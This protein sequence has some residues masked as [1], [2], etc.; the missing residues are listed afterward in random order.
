MMESGKKVYEIT[1]ELHTG[2]RF[3]VLAKADRMLKHR[4][5][6]KVWKLL[7][8]FGCQVAVVAPDLK[9]F[10]GSLIHQDLDSL[11]DK[12]D[13]IVPC[14]RP[15]YLEGLADKA[16]E[17]GAKYIWFQENNLTSVLEEQCREKNICVVRGCALKHKQYKKPLA[18]FNKCYWHGLTEKKVPGR[19]N[20]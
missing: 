4:H 3:V 6:W 18:F 16:E 17:A 10:E 20:K 15:E 11:K 12:V 14:L 5:A 8:N 7:K 1:D 2:M 19:Y 9:R 13:V